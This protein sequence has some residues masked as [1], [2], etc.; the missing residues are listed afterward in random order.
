MTQGKRKYRIFGLVLDRQSR[1]QLAGLRVEAWDKDPLF[2][3]L[4]GT[5][6]TTDKGEF[7]IEFDETYFQELFLDQYPDIFFRVFCGDTLIK[8]TED[9]VLWNTQSTTLQ[10]TLEV[11]LL[12]PNLEGAVPDFDATYYKVGGSLEYQHP[13]Y[14]VRQA[15][16]ELYQGLQDGEFCYVLNSRQMGKSSL[17]VQTMKR[18]QREGVKCA[19]IDMMRIGS[20][21]TPAEWYGGVVS[22]LIRGFGLT[23]KI[24]F[25]TWW[26]ERELLSPIQRLSEFIE[27]VLLIEFPQK[28]VIFIDEIDSILKFPFRNDFFAYV[29]TCYNKRAD[30]PDY[31]RLTFAFL[32]VATPSNLIA[33]R[34]RTPFNIGRAIAL[35]GFRLDEAQPLSQ[36]L[37]SKASN[38]QA[39]LKEVLAWTGGQPFLTQ[40]LCSLIAASNSTIARGREA[41]AV[42]AIVKSSI[43]HNWETQDEPEHLRTIRDRLLCDQEQSLSLLRLYRQ[44]LLRGGLP[45]D[46]SSEQ[47]LLQLS[48]VAVQ[49]SGKLCPYNRIYQTLFNINWVEREMAYLYS[50]QNSSFNKLWYRRN[51]LL[52]LTFLFV[53]TVLLLIALQP[54]W[55]SEKIIPAPDAY[56]SAGERVLIRDGNITLKQAIADKIRQRRYLEAIA[57]LQAFLATNPNEPEARVMLNNAQIGEL[58]HYTIAVSLPIASRSMGQAEELLRGAAQAQTEVNQQGGIQGTQLKVLIARDDND[59]QVA[60]QVATKLVNMPEVLGVVGHFTSDMTTA[61]A[62]IYQREKLVLVS[63]TSTAQKIS[64]LGSYI[65]RTIPTDRSAANVL[66]DYMIETLDNSKAVIYYCSDSEY[67]Q[68]LK[69]EFTQALRAQRGRVVAEF[70]LASSQFDAWKTIEATHY[71]QPVLVLFPNTNTRFQALEVVSSNIDLPLLGGD[72]LYDSLTLQ[73][74]QDQAIDMVVAIPWVFQPQADFAQRARKLWRADISWRTVTAFDATKALIAGIEQ[75]PTRQGIQQVLSDPNFSTDGAADQIRFTAPGDRKQE[76]ELAIVQPA[77]NSSFGTVFAPLE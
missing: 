40:K 71:H 60:K 72:D 3:D 2:D 6:I 64:Q 48:G 67:S 45:I 47:M 9:S 52:K 4:L 10:I 30:Q 35:N 32:G 75:N 58:P 8:T 43:L 29:R 74:G 15:D 38:P 46:N 42:E 17:R 36:G 63:P 57:D 18:L 68:S 23:S 61:A 19:S 65:F 26:R 13:T 27:D 73:D 59:P 55:H 44:I 76:M 53:L 62:P 69:R 25:S 24:N 14:I 70:D 51:R 16:Q 54:F 50:T 66:V 39:V 5:A 33:D 7:Q 20:D 34:N 22:E 1:Q 21:V 49:R 28:I 56:F 31:K 77:A 37:E 11:D 12:D 41:K